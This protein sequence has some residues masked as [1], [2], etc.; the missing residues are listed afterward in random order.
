[1]SD[2]IIKE[3]KETSGDMFIT[4]EFPSTYTNS[5][6]SY[7]ADGVFKGVSQLEHVS[8]PNLQ[9][10]GER[11]FQYCDNLKTANIGNVKSIPAYAFNYCQ[12]LSEI[13]NVSELT[14]IGDSAF[15]HIGISELSAPKLKYIG[16]YAFQ[17]CSGLTKLYCPELE[18]MYHSVQWGTMY[19]AQA[20]QGCSNLSEIY[21]PMLQGLY[22]YDFAQLS[23]LV[24][25]NIE[26]CSYIGDY[27][28]YCC[29][30]LKTLIA[31]NAKYVG[32]Q[33][34]SNASAL[35]YIK[36]DKLENMGY[37][38]FAFCFYGISDG[39][40][41]FPE[42]LSMSSYRQFAYCYGL[43]TFKAPKLKFIA[44]R[45]FET[46]VNLRNV[47]I[48]SVEFID[49]GA[50]SNCSG[51]TIISIPKCKTL[52]MSAFGWCYRMES[53]YMNV[54]ENIS[55]Y[56]FN[57][58]SILADIH[59]SE[60]TSVPTLGGSNVFYYCSSLAHIYVPSSLVTAFQSAQYWSQ[61]SSL[62]SGIY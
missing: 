23:N 44:E 30:S 61:Y 56:A 6:A 58:C 15:Y 40:A 21:A 31:P 52:G 43:E 36:M 32:S 57:G 22:S 2:V 13:P 18:N 49:G 4:R 38:A 42:L 1:M 62:I 14:Y 51:L 10:M 55:D 29:Y 20:F 8:F 9:S 26:N 45:A 5:K 50:F 7:I 60:I 41:E 37:G 12:S 17:N 27:A 3:Y 46:N 34:V 48:P 11:V 47:D 28:L 19:G 59:M 25:V 35:S 16:Q 39:Y 24:S 53:I 33:A 54:I